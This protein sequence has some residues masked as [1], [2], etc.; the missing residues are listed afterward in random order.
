VGETGGDG[1]IPVN[2]V[3]WSPEKRAS[4]IS[5]QRM[6][7]GVDFRQP[8]LAAGK[9]AAAHFGTD[10]KIELA[11]VLP[12]P[13]VPRFLRQVMPVL[14]DRL[15][16]AIASPLGALR[17]FAATLGAKHLSLQARVGPTVTALA[18][19]ARTSDADLVVLGRKTLDGSRGRTLERLIRR[20][21]TPSMVIGGHVDERPRRIL[22]AVDDAA[23]GG[24]V[25]DWAAGLAKYFG[26][27]LTLLHVLSDA[28]LTHKW[29][30]GQGTRDDRSCARLGR[31][32]RWMAPTHAWLRGLGCIEEQLPVVR[33]AVAVGAP[34]PVILER[35]RAIR[36]DLICG[37]AKRRRRHRPHGYRI[38]HSSDFARVAVADSRRTNNKPTRALPRPSGVGRG[39]VASSG[40]RWLTD[41]ARST[42]AEK[43]G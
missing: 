26:A 24:Y 11:Y 21:T 28:L 20:L 16:T 15:E 25:V 23:I 3:P 1:M 35:A 2:H 10:A 9:W 12:V 4:R 38:G 37:R 33:T 17:G 34:G 8:S 40:C 41:G 42:D 13:E 39:P 18:D 30:R 36:A 5:I 29:H 31:S 27:E 7:V 43:P 19:V 22:A 32:F 14:D 6:L